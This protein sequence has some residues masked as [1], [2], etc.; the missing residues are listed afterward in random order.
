MLPPA[1][2]P[3]E[4]RQPTDERGALHRGAG[5]NQQ[6]VG[7]DPT[8]RCQRPAPPAEQPPEQGR[9]QAGDNRNIKSADIEPKS[10]FLF[11]WQARL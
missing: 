1:D 2:L 11:N 9:K 10:M 8:R 5:A 3:G 6:G 7:S 4:E